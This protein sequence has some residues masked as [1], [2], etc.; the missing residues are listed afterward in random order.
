MQPL[1]PRRLKEYIRDH[2]EAESSLRTWWITVQNT[3]WHSFADVWQTFSTAS[4][5]QDRDVGER[6]IFNIKGNNYRL[7]AY[8]DFERGFVVL[9]WFGTHAA[10]DRGEWKT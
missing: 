6:V 4:Y 2:P 9:K 1:N 8:I 7:V 3:R 5:V 10:Y